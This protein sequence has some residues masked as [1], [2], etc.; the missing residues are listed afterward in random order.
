MTRTLS[1]ECEQFITVMGILLPPRLQL[2]LQLRLQRAERIQN[3]NNLLLHGQW[4]NGND[5]FCQVILLD[6]HYLGSMHICALTLKEIQRL[7]IVRKIL[8]ILMMSNNN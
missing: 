4:G 2:R 8:R 7:E 3:P 5:N 1:I 6:F